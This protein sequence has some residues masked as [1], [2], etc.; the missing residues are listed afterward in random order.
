MRYAYMVGTN[1]RVFDMMVTML[2]TLGRHTEC[3]LICNLLN[4]DGE[5]RAKIKDA[6]GGDV[7]FRAIPADSLDDGF[8]A[9]KLKFLLDCG[10]D[11]G[12]EIICL[13]ADGLVC[14]DIFEC[15]DRY[16]FDVAV[17]QRRPWHPLNIVNIGLVAMRWNDDVRRF[18]RHWMAEASNPQWP[19]F[20]HMHR[21]SRRACR[22]QTYIS[23]V[24]HNVAM[25]TLDMVV[26]PTEFN[27]FPGRNMAGRAND[28]PLDDVRPLY[29]AAMADSRNKFIHF[30]GWYK[31]LMVELGEELGLI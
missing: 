23:S 20:V 29:R 19:P 31:P 22:D 26:L 28:D 5:V 13:D 18:V 15:F 9:Y 24:L 4:D 17:T 14:G 12:D 16:L 6:F 11:R 2:P 27:Y 25:E 30:K 1:H 7:I 3:K 21:E 8:D 10:F